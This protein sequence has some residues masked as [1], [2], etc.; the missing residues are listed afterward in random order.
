MDA[1]GM[2]ER[3]IPARAGFIWGSASAASSTRD[4]PRSRGVYPPP[5]LVTRAAMGSSPLARG[6][7][8]ARTRMPRPKRIIP[9]RAGFMKGKVSGSRRIGDHPRSRGVY[10]ASPMRTATRPGSSPLARGLLFSH[11]SQITFHRIIPA[12]A[13]F[14]TVTSTVPPRAADHPRSRGVYQAHVE[15]FSSPPG[16][17][18]LARGLSTPLTARA[19]RIG[20][21]P[22][23]AGF[24]S[25][26]HHAGDRGGDHPRSRG[27]YFMV[28][29]FRMVGRG[30]SPLAR[31]L[32]D[33]GE[34][35]GGAR[36]IIPARAGFIPPPPYLLPHT[37]GSSPLARGLSLRSSAPR[38]SCG[39]IPARAGFILS[40]SLSVWSS[41]GIIPAR[42]GFIEEGKVV[43]SASQ[44]H[45][46]SR[47]VYPSQ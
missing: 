44:D 33:R 36:G 19:R 30:S 15:H 26:R 31:G 21:I 25:S 20:I 24:M 18:P 45:P 3:I 11:M 37:P 7:S 29:A 42:A 5:I 47:G 34:G 1:A 13:G 9:A 43:C 12:R 38:S 40:L 27:V 16:S 10:P 35:R 6:L 8:C 39:I 32:C 14:M 2:S 41:P 22:A 23:R 46:R 4:H 28:G 17:S